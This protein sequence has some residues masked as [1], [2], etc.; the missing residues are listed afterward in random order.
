MTGEARVA[1]RPDPFPMR[2]GP[3]AK[4]LA[5]RSP[6]PVSLR[7]EIN[8]RLPGSCRDQRLYI[9]GEALANAAKH[10][11]V[12]IADVSIEQRGQFLTLAV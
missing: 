5:C 1:G 2:L 9:A 4:A 7:A 12:T 6:V 10:A 3:A 8:G 11:N